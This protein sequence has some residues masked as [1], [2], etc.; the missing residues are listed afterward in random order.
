MEIALYIAIII[1]SVVLVTLVVVQART[2]GLSNRDSSSIYRTKRGLEKTMHQTT[3]VIAVLFLLLSLIASLPLFG[4][5]G[6]TTPL[7]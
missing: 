7:S 6:A 2:A 4:G 5:G 1:L 3:I